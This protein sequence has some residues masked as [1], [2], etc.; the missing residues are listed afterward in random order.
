MKKEIFKD[1]PGYEGLYQVSNLGRIKS[2]YNYKRDG[3]NILVPKIKRG[4]YQVGL[5]KNGIRKWHNIH[6]L[7]AQ[8]F[9]SNPNNY[10][11]VNHKNEDK[12][13]NRIENLE[14]CTISYNNC[15]GTRI[16]RVKNKV[17]KP[18][19]QYDLKGNFIKQFPSLAD[20]SRELKISPSNISH[21]ANGKYKTCKGYVWKYKEGC[22]A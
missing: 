14:W 11:V 20:A 4:Y 6:R 1:I 3:N 22:D 2:L 21:C 8:T 16:E 12:L 9:I 5:R 17:S 10:P 7:I 18:I 19:I 13:D 15:Y